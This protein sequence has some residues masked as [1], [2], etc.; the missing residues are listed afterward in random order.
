[1]G[2]RQFFECSPWEKVPRI[3]VRQDGK[4]FEYDELQRM[5]ARDLEF[6]RTR[7]FDAPAI[8]VCGKIIWVG[9]NRE[10]PYGREENAAELLI[11]LY[12]LCEENLM[13]SR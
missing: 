8:F 11:R 7:V 5:T 4:Q 3:V 13:A 9:H 6:C 12:D 10:I 1:M 2:V